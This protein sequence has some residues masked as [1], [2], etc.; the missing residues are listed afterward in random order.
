MATQ[1]TKFDDA[2]D[3]KKQAAER[4]EARRNVKIDQIAKCSY[5]KHVGFYDIK[6]EHPERHPGRQCANLDCPALFVK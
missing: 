6:C 5:R 4:D 3:A 2:I 1:W